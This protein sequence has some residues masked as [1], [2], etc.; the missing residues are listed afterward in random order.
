HLV[1]LQVYHYLHCINALRRAAYQHVYGAPTKEHLNHLDH[2]ID[3]LRQAAQ[4]QSDLT[5]MLYFN[6]E[7]DPNTMLI[8]SHQHSCRRFDLV[9]EW[10][11]ARS[12]CKG[13]TTCAIEVGKQVGGE[14]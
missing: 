5:P 11:M 10:A 9:N 8:K 1:S 3:M 6:P 4:C 14:M 12:Q 13:N 7:N 2:C